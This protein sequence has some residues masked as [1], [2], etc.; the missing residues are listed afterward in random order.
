[1]KQLH[2]SLTTTARERERKKAINFD[3][4]SPAGRP[5]CN[6]LLVKLTLG[7]KLARN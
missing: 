7:Y 2:D 6:L 4:P 1:M 3:T 5:G